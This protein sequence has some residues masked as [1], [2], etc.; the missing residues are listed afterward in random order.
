[1]AIGGCVGWG[2]CTTEEGGMRNATK[3]GKKGTGCDGE[4][5]RSESNRSFNLCS[6]LIAHRSPISFRPRFLNRRGIPLLYPC[7]MDVS[8]FL[9]KQVRLRFEAP[10]RAAHPTCNFPASN[11]PTLPRGISESSILKQTWTSSGSMSP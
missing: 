7:V 1:V 9:T 11:P 6:D 5:L 3:D 8:K 10:E 2:L 4:I